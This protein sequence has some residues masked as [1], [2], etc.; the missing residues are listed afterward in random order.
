MT[1]ID[2]GRLSERSNERQRKLPEIPVSPNSFGLDLDNE[3][4][5]FL[6]VAPEL[7]IDFALVKTNPIQAS[8]SRTG[9]RI[10]GHDAS[11]SRSPLRSDFD[12]QH[13]ASNR[14]KRDEIS[15]ET[16]AS[17]QASNGPGPLKSIEKAMDHP[18]KHTHSNSAKYKSLFGPLELS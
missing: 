10:V 15:S 18:Q 9:S 8:P 5:Q 3:I 16:E 1:R 17:L 7:V 12:F 14:L 11:Q 6:P 2:A 4:C 13:D